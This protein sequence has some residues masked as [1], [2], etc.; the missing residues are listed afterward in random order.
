MLIS[1]IMQSYRIHLHN[2]TNYSYKIFGL[3]YD[4][5]I[6]YWYSLYFISKIKS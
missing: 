5:Q 3:Y 1:D 4:Y 6:K 2:K